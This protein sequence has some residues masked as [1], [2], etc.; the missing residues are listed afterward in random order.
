MPKQGKKKLIRVKYTA[1]EIYKPSF[2]KTGFY[3]ALLG[4][5]ETVDAKGFKTKT[6]ATQFFTCR[7]NLTD[8]VR[9]FVHRATGHWPE[10]KDIDMTK[11]RM[12]LAVSK[13][14]HS[15]EEA[16]KAIFSAK[17]A[18]NIFEEA[19]GWAEP[20]VIT[21]VKHVECDEGAYVWLLTASSNWY[22]SPQMLS[23]LGLIMRVGFR[24]GPITATNLEELNAYFNK[25]SKREEE[26]SDCSYIAGARKHIVKLMK[27]YRSV[28]HDKPEKRWPGQ[29]DLGYN[30]HGGITTL[31]KCATGDEVLNKR[32]TELVLKAE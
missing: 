6:Q 7:E 10:G 28:F 26:S 12:I 32:F 16:K 30:G 13:E 1:A 25:L 17:R 15:F 22:W 8:H 21:T 27:V 24:N 31:M 20:A 4:P 23:L 3:F 9:N 11:V 19:A 2:G 14:D 18:I 5:G 29:G